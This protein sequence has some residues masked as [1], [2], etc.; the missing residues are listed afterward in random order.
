MNLRISIESTGDRVDEI[1]K[2]L[3]ELV[4]QIEGATPYV[5]PPEH[6][7][8][9]MLPAPDIEAPGNPPDFSIFAYVEDREKLL[10]VSLIALRINLNGRAVTS[11]VAHDTQP[12]KHD[13]LRVLCKDFVRVLADK[14]G[15][16]RWQ[17]RYNQ[18]IRDI[19][20]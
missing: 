4:D 12:I 18:L 14:Q 19:V 20:E 17:H 11:C 6:F 8:T 3:F 5:R 10:V 16:I 9:E 1:N 7:L 2:H 13:E 15:G